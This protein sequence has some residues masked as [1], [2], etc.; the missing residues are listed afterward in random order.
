MCVTLGFAVIQPVIILA[1]QPIAVLVLIVVFIAWTY[2][3]SY[4]TED[5]DS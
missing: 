3:L 2:V 5:L 4:G 1:R